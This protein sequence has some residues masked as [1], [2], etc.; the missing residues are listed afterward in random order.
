MARTQR[1]NYPLGS[2]ILR[3]DEPGQGLFILLRG[4]V[5]VIDEHDP[6][7]PVTLAT[8]EPGAIFGER[9]LLYASPV[10][11]T[12]RATGAVIVQQLS[13]RNFLNLVTDAQAIGEAMAEAIAR[14]ETSNFI[15][16]LLPLAPLDGKAIDG[17]LAIAE[18]VRIEAGEPLLEPGISDNAVWVVREGVLHVEALPDPIGK[19]NG[20]EPVAPVPVGAWRSGDI[21]GLRR[22]FDPA[23]RPVHL[24][25]ET[26]AILLRWPAT[27][28]LEMMA[29]NAALAAS[30][31][32]AARLESLRLNALLAAQSTDALEAP[33]VAADVE[34][35]VSRIETRRRGKGAVQWLAGSRHYDGVA[36]LATA[37]AF[38]DHTDQS[39]QLAEEQHRINSADTLETLASKA[40][41]LGLLGRLLRLRPER[42]TSGLLPFVFAGPDGRL[43]LAIG[44]NLKQLTYAD[45]VTGTTKQIRREA[46][47]SWWTG[48]ALSLAAVP[49]L[50]D[51]GAKTNLLKRLSPIVRPHIQAIVQVLVLTVIGLI[52]GVLMPLAT[53]VIIDRVLIFHDRSLLMLMLLVILFAAFMSMAA[54][55]ARSL[56][57][58]RIASAINGVLMTRLFA[59]VLDVPM[60]QFAKWRTADLSVRFE[61]NEKILD[62]TTK[63]ASVAVLDVMSILV[64]G[65]VLLSMNVPLT[66]VTLGFSIVTALVLRYASP[67]L[68]ANEQKAFEARKNLQDLFIEVFNGIEAIKYGSQ[69]DAITR[70]GFRQLRYA[71]AVTIA[72]ARLAFRVEIVT[73]ALNLA[74]TIVVLA[75]GSRW[76]LS[77]SLSAGELVAIAGLLAGITAPLQGI[78]GVYDEVQELR[79]SASRVSELL[80]LPRER[81]TGTVPCPPINGRVC[82][83]QVSFSYVE[84]GKRKV[85]D[86]INLDIPP[87]TKVA[88]VGGSGSGK[89]T[90]V[91]LINRLLDPTSG[92]VL[93]DGLDTTELEPVSL[94]QQIGVVEQVPHIFA[95]TLREN[96]AKA[97]PD[98]RLEAIVRA[99]RLSGAADFIE[100]L[101]MGYDTRIGEGGKVLSGGQAQRVVI[102]RAI[103]RDPRLLILD[104]A[105]SALDREA[106]QAV[107]R[108]LD[109]AMAGRTVFAVAH[110]LSTIRNADLIVV[111]EDGRVAE[112]GT[113][114][115]LLARDG[116]YA[117]LVNVGSLANI[118]ASGSV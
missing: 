87:G 85:L 59:H 42:L 47:N 37:V 118:D 48:R 14:Y 71:N 57:T 106:E 90:L 8:L 19:E 111:L 68:R 78:A 51:S 113:H 3:Q 40:D 101:P 34:N 10:I 53:G 41:R 82:F 88:V 99:A 30:L 62:L 52:I 13:P 44:L 100:R 61:E 105:T 4:R 2:I 38:I 98:L 75:L 77:G 17:L 83:E 1:L 49:E 54:S 58:L 11:A 31:E 23:A 46:L 18:T 95:G 73:E 5:R 96:I 64:F 81:S 22:L 25:A 74:A 27:T 29:G 69:E 79:I 86:K 89:S 108:S 66:L 9:S 15:R 24:V 45:P 65:A 109:A 107:Q 70:K 112:T 50:G 32:D 91:R 7:H 21:H 117:A 60:Q 84:D 67:R 93:I 20:S 92:R 80:D 43:K 26:E 114:E 12:L 39:N 94:R 102:A 76:V 116:I 72:G 63:I 28:L 115:S 55:A 56:L 35:G 110:R 33:P 16:S 103:A 97:A 104:E 36:C 6:D